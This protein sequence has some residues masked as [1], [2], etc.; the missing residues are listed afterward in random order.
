M[1]KDSVLRSKLGPI[2]G[3]NPLIDRLEDSYSVEDDEAHSRQDQ[4]SRLC[5]DEKFH[6]RCLYLGSASD[7]EV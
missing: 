1:L 3:S 6:L 7:D 5:T 4:Y 2:L